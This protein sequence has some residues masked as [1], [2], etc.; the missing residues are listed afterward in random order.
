[1]LGGPS[2]MISGFAG[3]SE[4]LTCVQVLGST[5]TGTTPMIAGEF[6]PVVMRKNTFT[7]PGASCSPCAE[8]TRTAGDSQLPAKF[9]PLAAALLVRNWIVPGSLID[10][11]LN[12]T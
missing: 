10:G 3:K 5:G 2:G 1:M 4:R 9:P 7:G 12:D 8:G 11:P 6:V